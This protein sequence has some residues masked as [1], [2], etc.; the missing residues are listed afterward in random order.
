[1]KLVAATG[2]LLF[3]LCGPALAD[4]SAP[5]H[6]G[7]RKVRFALRDTTDTTRTFDLIVGELTPCA[8]ASEKVPDHQIELRA[9]VSGHAQLDIEWFSRSAWGEY[10]STS[11]L[12]FVS[13]ATAEL[14]SAKGPHLGVA[15]Q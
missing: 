10:R 11:S 2:A 1:M 15:V 3:T 8:T 9:C 14:G 4:S 13:G 7:P 5:A 12:P 6:S